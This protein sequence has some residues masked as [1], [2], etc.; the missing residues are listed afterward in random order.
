MIC[1]TF[2]NLMEKIDYTLTLKKLKRKKLKNRFAVHP[3]DQRPEARQGCYFPGRT[4]L[5]VCYSQHSCLLPLIHQPLLLSLLP[6]TAK[7][8]ALTSHNAALYS[9]ACYF[10]A[11]SW[12]P[13][14][15]SLPAFASVMAPQ[16]SKMKS[17]VN[18]KA[19][20]SD[21]STASANSIVFCFC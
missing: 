7:S 17:S 6:Y 13:Y 8:S 4:L 9:S 15:F 20:R 16:S 3:P 14:F 10:Y 12:C 5:L 18:P 1:S 11:H 21:S 19:S 2:I